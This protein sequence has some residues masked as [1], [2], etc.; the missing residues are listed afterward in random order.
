MIHT[1]VNSYRYEKRVRSCPV[2][3]NPG[4]G[5]PVIPVLI[6]RDAAAAAE[7]AENMVGFMALRQ[8]KIY[9]S[10]LLRRARAEKASYTGM[11]ILVGCHACPLRRMHP[12]ITTCV[13][14]RAYTG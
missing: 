8:P 11:E 9:S 3:S 7:A 2:L 5:P 14:P 1:C 4:P 13:D 6:W 12:W 10:P